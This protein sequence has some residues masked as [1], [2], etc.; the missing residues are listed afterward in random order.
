[1]IKLSDILFEVKWAADT[2][3]NVTEEAQ[4][5]AEIMDK[6]ATELG[7]QEPVITS[8]LRLN[9]RQVRAMFD[10]WRNEGSDYLIKLYAVDCKSCN[11]SAGTIVRLLADKW[12]SQSRFI[13]KKAIKALGMSDKFLSSGLEVLNQFPEGLSA[14]KEGKALDYGLVSNKPNQINHLLEEIRKRNFAEF[15]EINETKVDDKGNHRAGSHKH[16]TVYSITPEGLNYLNKRSTS[17]VNT[18]VK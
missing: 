1:M 14:H 12:D 16:V 6:L 2:D 15:E 7:Y 18:L 9:D 8:G 5:F 17:S 11:K 10:I 13:P 3:S 4:K